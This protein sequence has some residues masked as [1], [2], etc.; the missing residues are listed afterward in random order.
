MNGMV[1]KRLIVSG[2]CLSEGMLLSTAE[3]A[4]A[5]SSRCCVTASAVS[6]PSGAK[7]T[8]TPTIMRT[9]P[10][11]AARRLLAQGIERLG[12]ARVG[13]ACQRNPEGVAQKDTLGGPSGCGT[14]QPEAQQRP[15]TY[16]AKK[17]HEA[18]STP[19]AVMWLFISMLWTWKKS[20]LYSPNLTL[21]FED[22]SLA[23]PPRVALI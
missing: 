3:C 22:F 8:R 10:P 14:Q 11:L 12:S 19:E 9:V 7:A 1:F 2:F 21:D 23:W 4:V 17:R 15:T 20:F 6:R 16:D 5:I 13:A 18:D